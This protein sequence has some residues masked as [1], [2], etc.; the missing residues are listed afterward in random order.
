MTRLSEFNSFLFERGIL[1]IMMGT[2]SGLAITNL[3]KDTKKTL[4]YPLLKKQN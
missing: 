2:I 4:I 3:M 1:G